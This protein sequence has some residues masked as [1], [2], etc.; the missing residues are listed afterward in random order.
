[1]VVSGEAPRD[2][3]GLVVVRAGLLVST[4]A[5]WQPWRLLDPSRA[6]VAAVDAFLRDLSAAGRSSATQRSYGLALLRWFRFL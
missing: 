2:L 1:M 5:V 3:A 6:P 4:G